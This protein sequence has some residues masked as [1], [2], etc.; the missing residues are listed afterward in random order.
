MKKQLH[1]W[2]RRTNSRKDFVHMLALETPSRCV[3][4][5]SYYVVFGILMLTHLQVLDMVSM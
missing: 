3:S 2:T 1:A 5:R 4:P